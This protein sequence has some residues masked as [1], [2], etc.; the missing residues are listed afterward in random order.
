MLFI[1]DFMI[2]GGGGSSIFCQSFTLRNLDHIR[3]WYY[4]NVVF[5]RG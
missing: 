3:P 5:I 4:I 2:I 1:D